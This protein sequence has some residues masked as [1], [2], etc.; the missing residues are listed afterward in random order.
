[1]RP[2]EHGPHTTQR[3]PDPASGSFADLGADDA[4]QRPISFP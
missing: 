1:M 4:Q 2:M 3:D